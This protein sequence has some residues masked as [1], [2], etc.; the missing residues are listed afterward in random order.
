MFTQLNLKDLDYKEV[1]IYSKRVYI[2]KYWDKIPVVLNGNLE[3]LWPFKV[4]E[5]IKFLD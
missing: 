3:L 5:I 4:D 1:D 2:D